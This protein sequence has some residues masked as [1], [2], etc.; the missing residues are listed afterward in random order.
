MTALAYGFHS[1]SFSDASFIAVMLNIILRLLLMETFSTCL[2]VCL[3]SLTVLLGINADLCIATTVHSGLQ[4]QN[5]D[6]LYQY[7]SINYSHP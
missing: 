7:N 3:C 2:F 6:H 1:A 5:L 4:H